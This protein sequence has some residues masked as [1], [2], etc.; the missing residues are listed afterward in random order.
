MNWQTKILISAAFL[1][2]MNLLLAEEPKSKP[3][4]PEKVP[5][6]TLEN[7]LKIS[8][9]YYSGGEPASEAHF[10]ALAKLGVKMVVSVDGARPQ[11]E[12][13]RKYGLRYVHIP[14]GY[15]GISEQ[16][17]KAFANLPRQ[18]TGPV[19]VHCHHGTHRGP[20]A[21]AVTSQ[22]AG[23]V[24]RQG[25]LEILKLAGTSK[26]YAGLWRDVQHYQPPDQD[27]E[28]PELV[29][30]A[31]VNSLVA[32]MAAMDRSFDN[33]EL[34]EAEGWKVP[35]EHPD[36]DPKQEA[37]IL[38][39]AF[40]E[41]ARFYRENPPQAA[42]FKG[43]FL[44]WLAEGQRQT[45]TLEA[46]LRADKPRIADQQFQLIRQSCTRCHQKYRN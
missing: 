45:S 28:L 5:H 37:L 4:Q 33:L 2:G 18:A 10:A 17:G 20:A 40:R 27:E 15:D 22:A 31:K 9:N 14:I 41:L 25:A 19:Y 8:D 34:C 21:A 29:E 24:D 44:K 1:L 16:A 13:A 38:K 3:Q 39:E 11:V 46:A 36:I 26:K 23:I 7:L 42:E 35:Q 12:L 30:Q 6:Q 32:A 43:P